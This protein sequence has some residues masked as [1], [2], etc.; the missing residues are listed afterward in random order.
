[1]EYPTSLN[2]LLASTKLKF[3]WV[4][5]GR[6]IRNIS[7]TQFDSFESCQSAYPWPVAYQAQF[8]LIVWNPGQDQQHT[9]W[10]FKLPLDEQ[11]LIIP[12]ARDALI[13]ELLAMLGIT[14]SQQ[15]N[16]NESSVYT[17]EPDDEQKAAIHAK[18]SK[19]LAEPPSAWFQPVQDYLSS[20]DSGIL[21]S[22]LGLQGFAD[23]VER[24]SEDKISSTLSSAMGWVDAPAFEALCRFIQNKKA[25]VMLITAIISRVNAS[26]SN[27]NQEPLPVSFY[28]SAIRAFSQ[29]DKDSKVTECI[30]AILASPAGQNIEVLHSLSLYCWQHL[31]DKKLMT[32]YLDNLSQIEDE[33]PIFIQLV[34][35]LM[36]VPDM[37]P[38]VLTQFRNPERSESLGV[39]IGRLMSGV[40]G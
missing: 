24:V 2:A 14:S 16:K 26:L 20:K 37:R 18:V 34:T 33:K 15:Q 40:R 32:Q 6:G 5:I 13:L 11:G 4:N 35:D 8:A 25:P 23:I 30:S 21:W 3:R 39:A 22:N 27:A 19:I 36:F 12:Q 29:A 31:K 9:I 17:F 1:M 38:E 10:F 28:D 7:Q